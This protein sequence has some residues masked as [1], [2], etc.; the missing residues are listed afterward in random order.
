MKKGRGRRKGH[1]FENEVAKMLSSW[2]GEERSF[3][4]TPL[5][6]GW[7]RLS[8]MKEVEQYVAGDLICPKDFPFVVECKKVEAFQWHSLIFSYD[9]SLFKQWFTH[10]SE[11]AESV[12]KAPF[13]I[14][15]RNRWGIVGCLSKENYRKL[16]MKRSAVHMIFEPMGLVFFLLEDFVKQVVKENLLAEFNK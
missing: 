16:Y 8:G 15:S 1:E 2:W 3:S 12:N 13:V 10:C 7:R 6:G 14:F 9:T 4:R 11:E 5:S